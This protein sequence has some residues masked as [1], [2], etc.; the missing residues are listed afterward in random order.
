MDKTF[1]K[2]LVLLEALA[3]VERPCGITELASQMQL[4]KSNVHRLLQS[5]VH[6]GFA[7]NIAETGRYELTMK[8]WELGSFVFRRLDVRKIA[9]S[10]MEELAR[11]TSETVHLSILDGIEVIYLAKIDSPQPVRSYT[12]IGGRA[13]AQC[14]AT[15]KAQLAWAEANTLAQVKQELKA[16]TPLSLLHPDALD[17]ELAHIR[18][19]G[20]AMNRGEWRDQV[21]GLAAPIRDVSGAVIAAIGISGPSLRLTPQML[22]QMAP[23]IVETG[24]IISEHLGYRPGIIDREPAPQMP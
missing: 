13:P 2:G 8:L 24:E 12:S 5:L 19:Q 15:G 11:K 17:A 3:R 18:H 21:C 6:Q 7:R 10:Y 9:A 14:V 4:N 1:L 16:Y 23:T 20:F 22:Q